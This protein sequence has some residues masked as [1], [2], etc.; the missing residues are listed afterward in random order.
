L[1]ALIKLAP[2]NLPR[3]DDVQLSGRV[4]V[5]TAGLT[6][7]TGLMFGLLPAWSATGTKPAMAFNQRSST[8]GPLRRRL[9]DGLLVAEIAL[10]LVVVTGA[11]LMTRT[12]YKI[13]HVDP[14]F[15]S[16]HVLTMRLDFDANYVSTAKQESFRR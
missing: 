13:A 11:G 6:L 4:L 14:G 10:A 7:L 1:A 9:F 3:I 5:F 8:S 16:D 2:P 12:M 15:Q